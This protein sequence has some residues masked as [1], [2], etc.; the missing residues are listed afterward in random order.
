MP[1]AGGEESNALVVLR[2]DVEQAES[3][4][5]LAQEREQLLQLEVGHVFDRA[6]C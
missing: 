1:D 4:A 6:I 5:A 3:Q 2:E